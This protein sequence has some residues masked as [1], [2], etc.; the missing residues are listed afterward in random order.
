MKSARNMTRG[1]SAQRGKARWA[2]VAGRDASADGE[3]VFAV[4]STG[5]FCRPS[6]PARRPRRSQV[7]FF[8][9]PNGA[10]R[11][12]F[13]ACLRCRPLSERRS[14]ADPQFAVVQNACREISRAIADSEPENISLLAQCRD[15]GL[16]M[17]QLRRAFRRVLGVTPRQY[18][19]AR[20]MNRLK[21]QLRSGADVTTA[22]YDAGFSSSSRLY[23]RTPRELGMTPATYRKGGEGM[24][25]GY[26]IVSSSVG[27]VLIGATE[28]GIAAV[29]L[30]DSEAGLT[31][32][33]H[34]EYPRAEIR[35][36]SGRLARSAEKLLRHL[37]GFQRE[38]DLP[39]D[40]Q[41]TAFQRC[42]WQA[43][44]S[45]PY[46]ETRTYQQIA[47]AIHKPTATRAVARACATNP[48]SIIVPC[49]RVVRGDGKLAGYRWG[50][51][52]KRAL[53]ERETRG[54]QSSAAGKINSKQTR[55]PK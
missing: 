29:Y 3:F 39:L 19:M 2:A 43:L 5:I 7:V 40:V 55:S 53:I 42:V 24:R 11:A 22:L 45:I 14:S 31:K 36:D 9:T 50:V 51:E 47:R 27:R 44:Q 35:R 41:A 26:T 4:R 20:K 33:L 25:I 13:R 6:C 8:A 30:G 52:R 37:N 16:S 23:E 1:H 28:K 12:G 15:S 18:A 34:K 38:V 46:G 17:H 48:V 10:Q 21:K 32:V 54:R 49:H